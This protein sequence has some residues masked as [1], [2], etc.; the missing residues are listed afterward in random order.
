MERRAEARALNIQSPAG[1][2]DSRF[3]RLC[4]FGPVALA[5]GLIAKFKF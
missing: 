1:W 4:A 5:L 3:R 2:S